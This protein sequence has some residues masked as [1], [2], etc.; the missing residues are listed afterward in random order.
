MNFTNDFFKLGCA[1][2]YGFVVFQNVISDDDCANTRK[3]IWKYL[4]SKV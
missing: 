1:T 3:E 4:E 2:R